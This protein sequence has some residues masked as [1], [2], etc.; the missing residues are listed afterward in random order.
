MMASL[1]TNYYQILLSQGVCSAIG[2]GTLFQPSISTIP[3]WFNRKRGVAYGVAAV[4]SS[5]GGVVFPIM[6]ARLIPKLGFPWAM[7]ISAFLMLA[8]LVVANLTVRA[9]LPPHPRPLTLARFVQPWTEMPFVLLNAGLFLFTF[10]LYIPIDFIPA[11]AAAAG[12]RMGLV[13][14]LVPILNAAR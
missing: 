14:Y 8:L 10:G 13:E 12:M 11:E 3:G 5:V 9:N 6:L 4:G 7:R 2:V 1:S